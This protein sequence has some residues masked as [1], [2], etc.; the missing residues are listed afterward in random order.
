ME[1]NK[2]PKTQPEKAVVSTNENELTEK[3]LEKVSGGLKAAPTFVD[4]DL[5]LEKTALKAPP[6]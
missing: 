3:Q 1:S 5:S 2:E 6:L 4:P